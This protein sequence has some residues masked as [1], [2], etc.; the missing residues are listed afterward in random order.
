MKVGTEMQRAKSG[1]QLVHVSR[2][3]RVSELRE[4]TTGRT[5]TAARVVPRIWAV[6]AP[7]AAVVETRVAKPELK[8]EL[9]FYRKYTEAL[10]RRYL[11][12]SMECGKVPSLMGREMFRGH[13]SSYKMHSFEDAVVFC[14]DVER[15]L[16]KLRRQ[17]QRII[18]RI[19]LQGYTQG[20]A[21]PTLGLSLRMCVVRYA[22]ALDRLTEVFLTARLLEPLKSCQEGTA[23]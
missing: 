17:D 16:A 5:V 21:A 3:V 15:C 1:L 6:A 18:Q 19:A 23:V 11:R 7:L 20:E 9:A 4:A 2:Q 14:I 13:V 12:A 22:E 8:V 10:I